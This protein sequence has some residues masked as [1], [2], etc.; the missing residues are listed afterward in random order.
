MLFDRFPQHLCLSDLS[1]PIM[2]MILFGAGKWKPKGKDYEQGDPLFDF[3]YF[4][5]LL[6]FFSRK[7]FLK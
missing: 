4:M 7:R 1:Q 2:N 5:I 3:L 6:T